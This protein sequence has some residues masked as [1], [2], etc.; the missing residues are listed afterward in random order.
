MFPPGRV[1]PSNPLE[2][3]VR[4]TVLLV[5]DDV[6]SRA[7]YGTVLRHSGFLVMEAD[8]GEAAVRSVRLHRPDIVVM[9][10]G[11]PGMDGWDATAALKGDPETASVPIMLLT[12]HSQPADLERAE[13]AGCDAYVV[14]PMDPASL[15]E[16]V[17]KMI[18]EMRGRSG[19]GT[20]DAGG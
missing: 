7:I 6:D 11:L 17:R 18:A 15:A 13:A 10:A 12:V 5:E 9:D 2:V 14:K 8:D 1:V 3:C 19:A 4:A 20:G 16:T